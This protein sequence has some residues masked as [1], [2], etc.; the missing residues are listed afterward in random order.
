MKKECFNKMVRYVADYS[1][2]SCVREKSFVFLYYISNASTYR[3]LRN[4][5]GLPKSTICTIIDEMALVFCRL[6][7]KD[8]LFPNS[9]EL[10]ELAQGMSRIGFEN[11]AVLAIDGTHIKIEKPHQNG[12]NYYNRHGVFSI[13]FLCVCDY[14]KRFRGFTYNY[15]RIHDSWV[16]RLSGLK[17]N[18]ES[19]PDE[20]FVLGDPAFSGYNKI[21][22]T[23]STLSNPLSRQEEYHLGAQRIKVEHAFGLFKGKFNRF[24]N[25]LQNKNVEKAINI[26]KGAIW[27]HNF[28]ID[29]NNQ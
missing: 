2:T 25:L 5:I 4:L 14:K 20:Y 3:V 1:N 7:H 9:E 27:I 12:W 13:N 29:N 28:I 17:N 8:V 24:K 21:K 10:P 6:T 19:L 26:I 11:N 18:V 22:S 16:Y 15:G 23:Y